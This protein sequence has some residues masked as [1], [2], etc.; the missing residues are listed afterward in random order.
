MTRGADRP[1]AGI[2]VRDS[3]AHEARRHLVAKETNIVE[4]VQK[5]L[6]QVR[7]FGEGRDEEYGTATAVIREAV[8]AIA[9][10]R[11]AGVDVSD[12]RSQLPGLERK[13]R[14]FYADTAVDRVRRI[15]EGKRTGSITPDTAIRDARDAIAAARSVGADVSDL[16]SRL[17]EL[18]RKAW[19]F[20]AGKD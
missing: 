17:P 19:R 7:K 10:A 12:L 15:G 5:A 2:A 16:E 20:A 18:E 4:R 9:D 6:D 1:G 13:A 11:S 14:R 3:G 8:D